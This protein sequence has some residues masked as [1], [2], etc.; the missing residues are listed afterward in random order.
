MTQQDKSRDTAVGSVYDQIDEIYQRAVARSRRINAPLTAVEQSLLSHIGR[1]PG[2]LATDIASAFSL[3]RSTVSRQLHA[4]ADLGLVAAGEDDDGPARRGRPL[5]V[6]EEGADRLERSLAIHREAVRSRL[7][8]WSES[9]LRDF[10]AA[11]ERFN[12]ATDA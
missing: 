5:H 1:N 2:C 6:T 3:N 9:E 11:L 8:G 12:S 7:A 4:L 10:A